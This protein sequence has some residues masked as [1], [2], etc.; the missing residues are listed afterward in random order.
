MR[1]AVAQ[2]GNS[3][4]IRIPRTVA[5][6]AGIGKGTRL[7]VEVEAGRIVLTPVEVPAITLEALLAGVTDQNIHGEIATGS[8]VGDEAW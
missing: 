5:A 1:T 3:L 2:W 4:A 8:V 7:Q 6:D